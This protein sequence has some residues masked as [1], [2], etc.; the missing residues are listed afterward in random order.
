MLKVESVEINEFRGIRKLLIEPKR[1][2]FAICGPNGTGKSGIVDAIEFVLTGSISRLV[3]EG[4]QG[5]RVEKHGPHVDSAEK[6]EQA[7]VTLTAFIPS[8]NR[9]ATISR[10]VSKASQPT[11]TPDDDDIKKVFQKIEDHPEFCLTRREIIRYILQ[12]PSDRAERVRALLKLQKIE[13]ARKSFNSLSKSLENERK[14]I[15]IEIKSI[16]SMIASVLQKENFSNDDLLSYVNANRKIIDLDELINLDGEF[17]AIKKE[18]DSKNTI[19]K[20][21]AIKD[22]AVFATCIKNISGNVLQG[23]L[24]DLDKAVRELNAISN[25]AR[26]EIT[27]SQLYNLALNEFVDEKCPVCDTPWSYEDFIKKIQ[28]KIQK[29]SEA[30]KKIKEIEKL[31]Q[32]YTSKLRQLINSF[33]PVK[34]Y[35]S[36]LSEEEKALIEKYVKSISDILESLGSNIDVIEKTENI[37]KTL[38][39]DSETKESINS[40]HRKISA[41]PDQSQKAQAVSSL[42]SLN[43]R[44]RAFK[45]KEVELKNT[46]Q[47]EQIAKTI[48]K[49]YNE[50]SDT[51]LETI[52]AQ[53]QD[54]FVKYYRE[55]HGPDE[56]GFTADL[57]YSK[58]GLNLKVDF[59]DR[60]QH[61]PAA[62]HS[63]GHQDGMGLCLY[64]ALMHFIFGKSFTF[65]VFDDVLMSVDN[66]HRRQVSKLLLNNFPQTQFIITT[67]D[68]IWRRNM[69]SYGLVSQ[70]NFIRFKSWTVDNGPCDW[71]NADVWQDIDDLLSK[72]D[73]ISA[74]ATLR[75]YLE[76]ISI[77]LCDNFDASVHFRADANYSLG[78]LLPSAVSTLKGYYKKGIE[79]A[80]A[81]NQQDVIQKI[82]L[83]LASL[84][85]LYRKSEIDSWSVNPAIHYN[86]WANFNKEEL[87]SVATAQKDLI[88][89]FYC[90][91]CGKLLK[92][93]YDDKRRK[94]DLR[95]LCTNI[96]V[97][98]R[99]N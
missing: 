98:L 7:F 77:E 97:N 46:T 39:V 70:N 54:N 16:S 58:G 37:L 80:K 17:V 49:K 26:K 13:E 72:N 52:Y 95:C 22:I 66:A 51:S 83:L 29:A 71:T 82:D 34:V 67:H 5:I 59:Y 89:A 45:T 42:S 43:D 14:Q 18:E 78:E 60:G 75:N 2:S 94:T 86:E 44:W 40:L 53:V 55:I 50:I 76:Y 19:S 33:F 99:K 8:L 61:P 93:S 24:E 79:A 3:G 35:L 9:T 36:L 73:I 31:V 41:L 96:Y 20:E 30:N 23:D 6:P 27:K 10:N 62:Y 12:R 84:A 4:T 47:K 68:E 25:N 65:S 88:S 56:G 15:E 57:S 21:V 1:K 92:L 69:E 32:D 87:R 48:N 64:L 28:E 63:E 74:S 91:D 85:D 11:I 81:L 90:P 38:D